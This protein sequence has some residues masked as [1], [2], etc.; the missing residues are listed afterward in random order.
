MKHIFTILLSIILL[1][2]NPVCA[3]AQEAY[4]V[5]SPDRTTLNF[6]Y[7][8]KKSSRQGT[9]YKIN[10]EDSIPKWVKFDEYSTPENPNF[11]TVV[12][13]ESFKDARPESCR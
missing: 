4:A 9:A 11:T 1:G 3:L 7:D 10:A 8:K 6:Y 13:D 12:F 5:K 2:T